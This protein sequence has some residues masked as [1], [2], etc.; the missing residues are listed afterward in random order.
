LAHVVTYLVAGTLAYFLIYRTQAKAGGLDPHMRNP[1]NPEEWQHVET[2]LIPA[3]ILRGLLFGVALCPLLKPL[4]EW[5]FWKRFFVLLGLLL[6]FSV[7]SVT[8]PGPGSIEGWLYNKPGGPGL[9][10]PL[11]G[12]IEVPAQ[13][14]VFSFLVSWWIG[15]VTRNRSVRA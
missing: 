2:W 12:Y 15:K 13:L 6:A 9:M 7:W 1:A 14:S 3:Q 8:M 4:S 5:Q 11:L 10:N